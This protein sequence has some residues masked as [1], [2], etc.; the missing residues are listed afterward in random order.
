[1]TKVI[2]AY[3]AHRPASATGKALTARRMATKSAVLLVVALV[4]T[5]LAWGRLP[6]MT[7]ETV[8]AEDGGVFLRDVL[9][10]GHLQSI[11]LPYDGYLHV[12]PRI[13]SSAAHALVPL[14]GYA[15]AMSLFSCAVVATISIGVFY[16]SREL[17][18]SVPVRVMIA[19][20]PV[21]LPIGP[22]EIQGNAANLHWYLLW[23]TP[24]LLLYRPKTA[25]TSFALFVVTFVAG[26]SEIITGMFLPLALWTALR[27]RAYAAPAGLVLALTL[28]ILTT[29]SKPRF[30]G[31]PPPTDAV[32]PLSVLMGYVLLPIGSLWHPDS[33]TLASG[34]VNFGPWALVV[35]CLLVVGLFLYVLMKGERTFQWAAIIALAASA[36]CWTASVV[37][38]GNSMF[39]YSKYLESNWASGFGYVRYAAAPAMFILLLIPIA[40]AVALKRGQIQNGITSLLTGIFVAVLLISYFPTATTRQVGPAWSPGVEAARTLCSSDP[41]L[42]S[43]AVTAAPA[44]W[45]FAQV[46]VPC[47]ALRRD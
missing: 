18:D 11:F 41:T 16:L 19:V 46:V 42:A 32:D 47:V 15:I 1:M 7:K 44:T 45:K 8:W 6:T 39:A 12:L 34:I 23:L 24:W 35:P 27:R 21:L 10:T 20:I 28:Q 3:P 14:D 43:A 38:S 33:R 29:L 9:S 30:N 25:V 40:A 4:L 37:L 2:E 36:L 26:A 5:F 17:T 22:N 31:A 13:L